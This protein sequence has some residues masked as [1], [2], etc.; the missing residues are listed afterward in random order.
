MRCGIFASAHVASAPGGGTIDAVEI[1]TGAIAASSSGT[2][3]VTTTLRPSDCVVVALIKSSTTG[4]PS[5]SG[6]GATWTNHQAG[7]SLFDHYLWSASGV[8]GGGTVTI[9]VGSAS[10]D[11]V[12]WV[13]RSAIDSPITAHG[14]SKGDGTTGAGVSVQ[15]TDIASATTGMF[16]VGAAVVTS[17]TLTFPSADNLPASGWTTDRDGTNSVCRFI[18]RELSA[19]GTVRMAASHPS[20]FANHAVLAGVFKDS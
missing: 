19:N 5:I 18:S 16:A 1:L 4:T 3:T 10:G 14:T 8:T 12:V 9:N 20:G 2:P 13:L 7:T 6:L 17:G 15:A 11:F